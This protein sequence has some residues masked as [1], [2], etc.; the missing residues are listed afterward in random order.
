MIFYKQNCFR[1]KISS[2]RGKLPSCSTN[3][4]QLTPFTYAK[5]LY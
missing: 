2:P 4:F 5:I 3:T 1:E